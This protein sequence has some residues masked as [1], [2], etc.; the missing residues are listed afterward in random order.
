MPAPLRAF[1]ALTLALA[2]SALAQVAPSESE[3]RVYTGLHAAAAA[4][5][6]MEIE[7]LL[8]AGADREARDGNGRTPLHVAVYRKKYDAARVLLAKGANANALDRQRYD[9]VTIA[10]VADDVPM[11]KLALEGGASAKNVTSPYDGTALIA[12]AH[13]GHVEVVQIL[14]RAGAPLDH[15]NN[16]TWTALME[17]IVLGDGGKR[18][19][20]TL[21]AL[22]A[23]GANVNIPD[24]AGV[25]PLAHARGRGYKEMTGILEKAG[26][27]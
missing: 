16:L 1:A 17:S 15:I 9:V 25:T 21:R 4:G 7:R 14:I 6:V 23:A 2:S 12:A 26:A 24:R 11:L 22:V 18:H 27:R 8:V 13:L 3:V 20:E 10:A 19:T 5:N